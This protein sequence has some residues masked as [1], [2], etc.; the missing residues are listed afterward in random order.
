MALVSCN[1]TAS[2]A[3]RHTN[4]N[5][6]KSC[7]SAFPSCRNLSHHRCRL[8]LVS[9]ISVLFPPTPLLIFSLDPSIPEF[10]E[11]PLLAGL[12]FGLGTVVFASHYPNSGWWS[13]TVGANAIRSSGR[14]ATRETNSNSCFTDFWS[15][16][17]ITGLGAMV[18][19]PSLC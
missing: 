3:T 16:G 19:S 14:F 12:L 4:T 13:L 11:T 1:Q 6:I 10:L 8:C 5:S 2:A 18:S 9:P 15:M 7:D 17:Q